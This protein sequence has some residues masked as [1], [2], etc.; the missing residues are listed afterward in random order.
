MTTISQ[1]A[2][3]FADALRDGRLLH[4]HCDACGRAFM[5]PKP[6]CPHCH[7]DKVAWRQASGAG[8]LVSMTV[9]RAAVPT[10]FEP[11][12][13]YALGVVRLAEGVTLLGRLAPDGSGGWDSYSLDGPVTFSGFT[14]HPGDRRVAPLF[15][16]GGTS[17]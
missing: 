10:D 13:P 11:E 5:Y 14:P 17:E 4:H 15:A 3:Q 2:T 7:S 8:T 16:A 9:Q 12:L 6:R 1:L